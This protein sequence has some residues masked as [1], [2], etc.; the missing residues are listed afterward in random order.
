MDKLSQTEKKE[1]NDLLIRFFEYS[2]FGAPNFLSRDS[3][4]SLLKKHL[5]EFGYWRNKAR[6][7]N[8]S[9]PNKS[10]LKQFAEKKIEETD[11]CPF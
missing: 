5:F 2:E 4:A 9:K 6:N 8:P 11:D 1:L 7:K 3:T 10:L